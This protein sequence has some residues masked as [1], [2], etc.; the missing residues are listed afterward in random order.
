MYF[1]IA[2]EGDDGQEV[3]KKA[4][5]ELIRRLALAQALAL[6]ACHRVR[7]LEWLVESKLL[8]RDGKEF[9]ALQKV[10]GPGYNEAY[11]WFLTAHKTYVATMCE[12]EHRGTVV[13]CNNMFVVGASNDAE[14]LMMHLNQPVP[15]AYSHLL[16][17]M[18]TI[19]VLI[20][21]LALVPSLLWV[22]IFVAPLVTLFFYGFYLLGTNMLVSR[23]HNSVITTADL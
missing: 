5:R 20:T 23:L 17:V 1:D 18:V 3:L 12:A 14:D 4:R 2:P 6:Q 15:L 11:S 13:Y 16:E 8:T 10:A 9:L 7:D 21:P 19:Y 22:A